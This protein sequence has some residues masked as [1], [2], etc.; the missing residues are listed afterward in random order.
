M[1]ANRTNFSNSSFL[2]G[3][4]HGHKAK[5]K[6]SLTEAKPK[7]QFQGVNGNSSSVHSTL[8]NSSI[9][10][11][12]G[13]QVLNLLDASRNLIFSQS[14]TSSFISNLEDRNTIL[15]GIDL[16]WRSGS[17]F[18]N[19]DNPNNDFYTQYIKVLLHIL[20]ANSN[21]FSNLMFSR[22]TM[23]ENT[24]NNFQDEF[25]S[26][27][28]KTDLSGLSKSLHLTQ[29]LEL[30]L[31]GIN[32]T[33]VLA[34]INKHTSYNSQGYR[35]ELLAA[36]YLAKFIY[37]P[38]PEVLNQIKLSE[39]LPRYKRDINNHKISKWRYRNEVDIVTGDALVSVKSGKSSL[40]CQV[41][42]LFF[43]VI[44]DKDKNL[45]EKVQK[46]ILI[47]GSKS[48]V[49]LEKQIHEA[50]KM[51]KKFECP[52]WCDNTKFESY[53]NRLVSKEGIVLYSM[54]SLYNFAGLKNWIEN[55]YCGKL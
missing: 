28:N 33:P 44:D 41:R 35:Y 11:V 29:A 13:S 36:W 48:N 26:L 46:L 20:K 3:Y 40:S 38:D 19:L 37:K 12:N 10:V 17:L 21:Y 8:N 51:I 31:L 55:N 42:D 52:S 6:N 5:R 16:V 34:H 45:K 25:I 15:K 7:H 18:S 23:Y 54:P 30:G 53:L 47:N 14:E 2:R 4:Y 50:R 1:R 9:N 39:I 32:P 24:D 49:D 43:A 22:H 27:A